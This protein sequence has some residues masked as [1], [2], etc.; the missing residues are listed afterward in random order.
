MNGLLNFH[1][2]VDCVQ[3][4]ILIFLKSSIAVFEMLPFNGQK[5][6]ADS[7]YVICSCMLNHRKQKHWGNYLHFRPLLFHLQKERIRLYYWFLRIFITMP[8]IWT[9]HL[10]KM[11]SAVYEEITDLLKDNSMLFKQST[12]L[13]KIR[14]FIPECSFQLIKF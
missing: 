9:E 10:K 4:F 2:S 8:Y 13:L 3:E 5:Y 1:L 7:H 6:R 11:L 12:T 14:H